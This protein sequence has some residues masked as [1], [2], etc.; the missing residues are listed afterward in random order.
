MEKEIYGLRLATIHNLAFYGAMMQGI[1]EA[2]QSN[3]LRTF[4]REFLAK[5]EETDD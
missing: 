5:M 3:Q 1:R 2:V 4:A